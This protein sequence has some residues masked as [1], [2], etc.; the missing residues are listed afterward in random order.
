M[1]KKLQR[2]APFAPVVGFCRSWVLSHESFFVGFCRS[3]VLFCL[4]P[5]DICMLTAQG[6]DQL[7]NPYAPIEYRTTFA[8]FICQL[9][10]ACLSVCLVTIWIRQRISNAAGSNTGEQESLVSLQ[11]LLPESFRSSRGQSI[12][13]CNDQERDGDNNAQ[14]TRAL[15]QDGQRD[16][17]ER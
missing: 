15:A 13:I 2:L 12:F 8:F 7:Q 6:R 14:R 3:G 16:Y 9:T 17:K 11:L 4:D 10:V 5:S 1:R